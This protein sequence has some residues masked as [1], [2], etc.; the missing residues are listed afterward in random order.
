MDIQTDQEQE[1]PRIVEELT[2]L[3]Q[4]RMSKLKLIQF[5]YHQAS[6]KNSLSN[7]CSSLQIYASNAVHAFYVLNQGIWIL[8]GGAM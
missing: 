1:E 4:S 5:Q 7:Y 2:M 6:I 3:E 8:D